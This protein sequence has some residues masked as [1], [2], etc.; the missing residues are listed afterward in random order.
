VQYA[1]LTFFSFG[2]FVVLMAKI[3]EG[4]E[5]CI[6]HSGEIGILKKYLDAYHA[7]V[8]VNGEFIEVHITAFE[9]AWMFNPA[10]KTKAGKK[11]VAVH[12]PTGMAG[13]P[14]GIHLVF[15]PES[16]LAGEIQRYAA[17][18][19]NRCGYDLRF[20]YQFSI[21]GGVH[22]S[23]RKDLKNGDDLMLHHFKQDQLND[24]P[25]FG[26]TCWTIEKVEAVS[27]EF[28][29]EFRLKPKQFFSGQNLMADSTNMLFTFFDKLPFKEAEKKPTKNAWLEEEGWKPVKRPKVHEV[30]EKAQMA[31]SIDLH[32]EK[33]DPH[34]ELLNKGEILDVQLA[35]AS[36][37]I[38]K[39]IQ[40]R[41]HKIYLVHG[42]GKGVLKD[43][44][45]NLLEQY[46]SVT[47]FNN[48]YHG[49]F[50]FGATEVML[51]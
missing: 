5:V 48:S 42:L 8:D 44:I 10:G 9:P 43:A 49:R 41:L 16:N 51:E 2:N 45:A 7:M 12:Q 14:F 33:L 1:T 13:L 35:Q 36:L 27:H 24:Q 34:W 31:D 29:K 32:I 30:L 28:G 47:S 50:G 15:V 46:P 17:I 40:H 26:L 11:D 37:F 39:A 38:E 25:A 23:I 20:H 22:T 3:K 18:L 21:E 6:L 4:E 19:V